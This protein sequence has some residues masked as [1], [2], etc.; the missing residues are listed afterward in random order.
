M[1]ENKRVIFR[2]SASVLIYFSDVILQYNF[3]ECQHDF[4]GP[5]WCHKEFKM[6]ILEIYNFWILKSIIG[7]IQLF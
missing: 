3:I 4:Y 5:L 2:K 1:M 7:F 6:M